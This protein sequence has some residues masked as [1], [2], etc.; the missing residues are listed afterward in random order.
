MQNPHLAEYLIN[1]NSQSLQDLEL[2][3]QKLQRLKFIHFQ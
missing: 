3:S 1:A 2:L